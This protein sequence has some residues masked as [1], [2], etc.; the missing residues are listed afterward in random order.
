MLK[1][2]RYALNERMLVPLILVAA[3]LA[4]PAKAAERRCGW[5]QNPTPANWSLIDQD[6]E[7]VIGVQGGYQSPGM[8]NIPDLSGREWK[9]VNG[10]HGY[11]CA[12]MTVTTDKSRRRVINI[13]SVKQLPLRQCRGDSRLPRP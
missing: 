2:A 7:W 6:G 8:D 12:C 9:S 5:V 3:L 11:G 4:S 13:A 1:V 10:S